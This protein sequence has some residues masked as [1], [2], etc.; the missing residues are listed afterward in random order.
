MQSLAR[1]VTKVGVSGEPMPVVFPTWEQEGMRLR[2]AEVN[3]IAGPPGSGKST[4][5]LHLAIGM[6]LPTCYVSAD[7]GAFT[8]ATRAIAMLTGDTLDS[9]EEKLEQD[10]GWGE[11][12]LADVDFI[13]WHFSSDPSLKRIETEISAYEEMF[14][15]YPGLIVVDNLLDLDPEGVA[16][17][18]YMGF[19]G[20]IAG[21]KVISRETGACVLILHHTS[22]AVK[23]NPCPPR[24]ALQGKVAQTPA[25]IFTVALDGDGRHMR[26]SPVKNRQGPA[27]LTGERHVVLEVDLARMLLREPQPVAPAAVSSWWEGVED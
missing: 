2:R 5:A 7:T 18:S 15:C 22:E 10:P 21:L 9:V 20:L 3:M 1:A 6:R 13:R 4:L 23:G 17:E 19:Q 8:M 11:Q 27:D 25:V 24:S 16:D 26:I 14:G 12:V